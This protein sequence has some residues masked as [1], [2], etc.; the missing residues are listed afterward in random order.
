MFSKASIKKSTKELANGST[1][2]DHRKA[3]EYLRDLRSKHFLENLNTFYNEL[4]E[5]KLSISGR[6]KRFDTIIRKV[7]RSSS[8]VNTMGDLI[9]YRIVT[10]SFDEQEKVSKIISDL[11]KINPRN[12]TS[13]A[14]GYRAIHFIVDLGEI[15]NGIK[16]LFEIQIRTYYQHIWATWSESYGER[17]KEIYK[18]KNL[19]ASLLNTKTWLDNFTQIIKKYEDKNKSKLQTNIVNI[20]QE[21]GFYIICFD[22][23][24]NDLLSISEKL[25]DFNLVKDNYYTLEKISKD[26]EEIVLLMATSEE[27]LRETHPR[28]FSLDA[29][30]DIPNEIYPH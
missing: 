23:N 16:N 24:K 18:S 17:I 1:N 19:S 7:Q 4:S 15:E 20:N 22:I 2:D 28:Y 27:H 9:G 3:L 25:S 12:Y 6:L 5:L 11:Y 13:Q 10:H 21:Y 30:P 8:D 29:R 26:N 14:N